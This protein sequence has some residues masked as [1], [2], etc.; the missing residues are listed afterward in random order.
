MPGPMGRIFGREHAGVDKITLI[1]GTRAAG[2]LRLSTERSPK[3]RADKL[4]LDA[5]YTELGRKLFQAGR[6]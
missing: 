6:N 4:H 3:W 1:S 5:A 2:T